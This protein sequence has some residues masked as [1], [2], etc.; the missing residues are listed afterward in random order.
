[1]A[2]AKA[3]AGGFDPSSQ[4]YEKHI[5]EAFPH[6][7]PTATV[8]LKVAHMDLTLLLSASARFMVVNCHLFECSS[9]IVLEDLVV[10]SESP[11]GVIEPL[12]LTSAVRARYPVAPC[13]IIPVLSSHEI[14]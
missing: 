13:R 4:V 9:H 2:P 5:A 8:E 7:L 3:G 1:M 6:N 14:I 11:T 12:M 10:D